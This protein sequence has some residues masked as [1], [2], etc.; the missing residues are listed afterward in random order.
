[1]ARPSVEAERREQILSAACQVISEQ[2][3]KALRVT[4]VARLSKVSTGTV[5]YYFETKRDLAN[6]AFEWNFSTSQQRRTSLLAQGG[7]VVDRLR[8][9]VDT[10]VPDDE[11]TFKSWRVWV[12]TWAEALHDQEL[13]ALN[14]RTYGEWRHTV[15]DLIRLGQAEGSIVPGDP[16][17]HA[18]SSSAPSTAWPFRC[19]SAHGI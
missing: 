6:A 4:D 13:Q 7:S 2:G 9:F 5:H 15:A 16:E 1:M 3:F 8:A 18:H 19:W 14:E 17:M 10:Y 11:V 12:E